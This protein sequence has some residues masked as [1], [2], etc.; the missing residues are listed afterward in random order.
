[1]PCSSF[2]VLVT[3]LKDV[4]SSAIYFHADFKMSFF[5]LLSST[6]MC[7]CTTFSFHSLVEGHLG[8][9]Q[10]LV[11]MNNAAM[12]IVEQMSL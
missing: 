8:C 12:Y 6:L 1:M 7:K 3:S 5:F 2:W 4:F 11:I 9:L 10:V